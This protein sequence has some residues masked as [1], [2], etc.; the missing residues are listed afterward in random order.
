LDYS[1][2]MFQAISKDPRV[3]SPQEAIHD[4]SPTLPR[5]LSA[6]MF[7]GLLLHL[8]EPELIYC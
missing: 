1:V 6:D 4:V 3:K 8:G 7:I 5:P 2:V